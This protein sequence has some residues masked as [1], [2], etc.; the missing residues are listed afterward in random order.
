MAKFA[1]AYYVGMFLVLLFLVV[2]LLRD[3]ARIRL[4][5]ALLLITLGATILFAVF[6]A[7]RASTNEK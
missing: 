5:E 3:F 1:L 2:S 4:E 6:A 7:W